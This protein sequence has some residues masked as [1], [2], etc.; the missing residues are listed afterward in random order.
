MELRMRWYGRLKG[1]GHGHDFTNHGHDFNL[2]N[3]IICAVES[4]SEPPTEHEHVVGCD[5]K[6]NK[7]Y[8]TRVSFGLEWF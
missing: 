6:K 7:V 5:A 3:L 4:V 1:Q 8:Q 2:E